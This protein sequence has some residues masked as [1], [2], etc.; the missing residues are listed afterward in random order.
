MP[1]ININKRFD[2]GWKVNTKVETRQLIVEGLKDEEDRDYKYEYALTDI[3]VLGSRKIGAGGSISAGYL[4]RLIDG[5]NVHRSIQQ[6]SYVL[7]FSGFRIGQRI[8]SDQTFE[9][10]ED[11]QLR[12][13]YRLALEIALNGESVDPHEAYLKLSNEY[14]NS[15]QGSE[16][17][18][19]IRFIPKFGYLITDHNKFEIGWDYRLDSFLDNETRQ[20]SWIRFSWYISL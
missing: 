7:P 16:H 18:L 11:V 5:E 20:S 9:D 4:I 17:D 13:R 15:F 2:A 8:A 1:Q 6:Y 3:S 14:L 10:G 19:E 12:L